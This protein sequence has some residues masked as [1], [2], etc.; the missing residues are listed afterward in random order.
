MQLENTID[1]NK[2]ET[3]IEEYSFSQLYSTDTKEEVTG[4]EVGAEVDTIL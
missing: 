4:G 2:Y 3:Q 1:N